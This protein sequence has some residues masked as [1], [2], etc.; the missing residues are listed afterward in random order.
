ML[1]KLDACAIDM[2]K[3]LDEFK[4]HQA[5]HDIYELVWSS[6][7]DWFIEA[8]KVRFAAGGEAREQALRVLDYALWKLLRLLHPFMPFITEELAHQMGFLAE[9][10]SIMYA[11]FPLP[12]SVREAAIPDAES[13]IAK[14][15]AKF[16]L[17]S[18][19][20]T[21]RISYNIAPGKKIDFHIKAANDAMEE[22]L[23]K[24]MDS[25]KW[26]LNAN[27]VTISQEDYHCDDASG[28]PSTLVAAGAIFLPLKGLIDVEAEKAKLKKQQTELLG[29]I[30][31]SEAKL[32]NERFLAK[33]PPKVVEEAKAYLVDLKEK[34][35]RVE[36]ALAQMK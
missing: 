11:E 27:S 31:S 21:L 19:G 34:L 28:A 33:A 29:W 17:I 10:E 25:L 9:S 1:A 23:K 4:F 12:M 35:A 36:S 3:S 32:S 14:T 15:E 6:F 26:L 18:A 13:V 8:S 16:E 2:K 20:R 5:V 24:G 7:C 30:R 22:F